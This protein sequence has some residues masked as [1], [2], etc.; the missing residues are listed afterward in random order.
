[1]KANVK[2]NIKE[3]F[4]SYLE[5]SIWL[6]IV[7]ESDLKNNPK[8]RQSR[9]YTTVSIPQVLYDK[10]QEFIKDTGF[11]SVSDFVTWLLREFFVSIQGERKEEK[12]TADRIV[13]ALRALGYL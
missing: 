13:K 3:I 1:M 10:I 8:N 6:V 5:Y 11:K 2:Q 7:M 12:T 9:K 4:P